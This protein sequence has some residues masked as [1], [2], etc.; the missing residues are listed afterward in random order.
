MA[1]YAL[2]LQQTIQPKPVKAGL[3]NGHDT[4][5]RAQ[6]FDSLVLQMPQ[7]LK[8]ATMVT[9]LDL[10]FRHLVTAWRKRCH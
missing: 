9:A 5:R 8:Q 10:V 3:L 6:P 7:Q 1:L 4:D 2:R